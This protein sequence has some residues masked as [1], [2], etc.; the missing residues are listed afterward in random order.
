[1]ENIR[2]KLEQ[3]NWDDITTEMNHR[4][5]AI[6]PGVLSDAACTKL[7]EGYDD[8]ALYRKTVSMERFRFGKG[9]YRYFKYP[10]PQLIQ[11]L[12]ETVYPYLS[13]IAN[14]WM[15]LLGTDKRFP[16]NFEE[17]Q[18]LCHNC[19]Q[20]QP[21]PLILKYGKGGYNT[22]H[23]DLY[24]DVFFPLQTVLFLN[25]PG[26]DYTGG[27]FI[28]L[29]QIP[30]AQSKAIVLQLNRGDLLIFATNFRPE[31]GLK[32]YYR[33]HMK[34]GVAEIRSGQRHTLGLIFHDALN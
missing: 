33:V 11:I 15:N 30:R 19:H 28:L 17:L 3:A 4:G 8:P 23:Q 27:E 25:Q 29:E 24:G 16:D 14:H 5:Y 22:L 12:R 2:E 21:T 32:G 18:L 6:I 34:H 10:L 1:M 26:D 31:K 13:P 7:I 20:Q 9:A